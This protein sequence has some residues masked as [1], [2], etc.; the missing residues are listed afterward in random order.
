MGLAVTT[1]IPN[2]DAAPAIVNLVFL[3]LLF[4]SGTFFPI[5]TGSVLAKVASV[6]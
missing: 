5:S 3:P 6:S 4:I 1:I 2:E